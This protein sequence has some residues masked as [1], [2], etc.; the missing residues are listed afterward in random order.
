MNIKN[1]P[2]YYSLNTMSGLLILGGLYGYYKV[3]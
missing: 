1:I 3:R 2:S